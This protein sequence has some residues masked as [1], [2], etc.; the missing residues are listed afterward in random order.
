MKTSLASAVGILVAFWAGGAHA[1]VLALNASGFVGGA[2]GMGTGGAQ[3]DD[4]FHEGAEGLAYGGSVGVE[5]L[6]LDGWI[7]H[8]QYRNSDGLAGTWT[9]FMLGVDA[10]IGLG[11]PEIEG[12]LG[13]GNGGKPKRKPYTPGFIDLG[14]GFGFGVGT[15]QQ[16]DPPL[17]YTE[18]TDRGFLL[19]AHAQVGYRL[20]R[21]FSLGVK[22]PVQWGYM[23]KK[24]VAND[25]NNHYQSAQGAVLLNLQMK[26]VLK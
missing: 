4:A 25:E 18:V 22:V 10:D 8:T 5:F 21:V 6:L 23:F 1:D 2:S 13:Q 26:F 16:I 20:N 19:Q 9:Q 7:D 24:G 12:T 11:E 17:D 3:K 14:I 15:G